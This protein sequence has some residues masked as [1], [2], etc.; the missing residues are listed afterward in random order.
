MA[1]TAQVP[2]LSPVLFLLSTVRQKKEIPADHINIR[3][4]VQDKT[5]IV[6]F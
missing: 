5:L 3:I 4:Q 1:V 2:V 6:D